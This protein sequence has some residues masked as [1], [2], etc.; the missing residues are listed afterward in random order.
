[1][2][3]RFRH[4]AGIAAASLAGL[5]LG[6]VFMLALMWQFAH[7][8]AIDPVVASD[9]ALRTVATVAPADAPDPPPSVLDR[10]LDAAGPLG[11]L[12]LGGIACLLAARLLAWQRAKRKWLRRGWVGNAAA[13]SYGSL[14][15]FGGVLALG[16][17][18][19]SGLIAIGGATFAGLGLAR[20]SETA[21]VEPLPVARVVSSG[22]DV[23]T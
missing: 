11:R 10:A 22:E 18:I 1:M 20:D 21:R 15:A 17:S 6:V 16:G 3:A 12:A 7:A 13:A 19:S 9:H 14:V 5:V 4:R 2:T 8:Q 23:P